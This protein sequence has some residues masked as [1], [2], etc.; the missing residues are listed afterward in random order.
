[1]P[2]INYT[3]P[4]NGLKE[5]I[6]DYVNPKLSSVFDSNPHAWLRTAAGFLG[7]GNDD[8][9]TEAMGMV[10]P[11]AMAAEGLGPASTRAIK[12]LK[13]L[14]SRLTGAIEQRMPEV[15]HPSKVASIIKN[16]AAPEEADMRSLSTLLGSKGNQKVAKSEV[17]SH[18][19]QN[20]VELQVKELKQRGRTSKTPDEQFAEDGDVG[21]LMGF[22]REAPKYSP[23]QV[24]GGENYKETL[25]TKPIKGGPVDP[26]DRPGWWPENVGPQGDPVFMS[27]HWDEPNVLAHV[28]SNDR[29][30]SP[31]KSLDADFQHL[32]DA[33]QQDKLSW[34]DEHAHHPDYTTQKGRFLEEV[35][36]D[37]HQ[38]GK[39]EGYQVPGQGSDQERLLQHKYDLQ[40]QIDQVGEDIASQYGEDQ[41]GPEATAEYNR[42]RQPLHDEL[43]ALRGQ[44]EDVYNPKGVPDAPFKETWPDLALKQQVLDTVEDPEL[45]WI[46][47]STGKTQ[48]D[49][50]NLSHHV[51]KLD[52]EPLGV[53]SEDGVLVGYDHAGLESFRKRLPASEVAAQIG[54][55][56]AAKLLHESSRVLPENPIHPEHISVEPNMVAHEPHPQEFYDWN[57][58]G[59]G[60]F[61][62]TPREPTDEELRAIDAEGQRQNGWNVYHNHPSGTQTLLEEGFHPGGHTFDGPDLPADKALEWARGIYA[63]QPHHAL[64]GQDLEVG[65]EGMNH[66]Y[67][68]VLPSRLSKILKPFGGKVEKGS[69]PTPPKEFMYAGGG[70]VIPYGNGHIGGPTAEVWPKWDSNEPGYG[71]QRGDDLAREVSKS[72]QQFANVPAW[73]AHL[74][75]EMK[76]AIKKKGLPLLSLLGLFS[77]DATPQPSSA[78][79]LAGLKGGQ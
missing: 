66:F 12:G 30:L 43:L 21:H 34:L 36:S 2:K 32:Q 54:E 6:S 51:S 73:I 20:P 48:N 68:N 75:P 35:Q 41:L 19:E 28:R 45:S 40:R 10:G 74:S 47:H 58:E 44:L 17:L 13:G 63:S 15:A 29:S 38:R 33:P 46:G 1:M 24:P 79:P 70:Q 9:S 3:A 71:F 78:D 8:P 5:A 27:S 26:A 50:Y 76:E 49:R 60:M 42:R 59:D 53:G 37:W 7:A 14:Y 55:A 4:T 11:T 67:D 23:W 65:G 72:Q 57:D 77:P 25:I 39:K 64:E 22:D 52:W 62:L 69:I 31:A 18:L 16:F 56:P 61:D